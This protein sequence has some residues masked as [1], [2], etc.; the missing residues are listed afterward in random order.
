MGRKKP[1]AEQKGE[2]MLGL[3]FQYEYRHEGGASFP[4]YP[5][6]WMCIEETDISS[7][8]RSPFKSILR[9]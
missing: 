6:G 1:P 5:N 9:R 7:I 3:D 2:S 8:L 4:L